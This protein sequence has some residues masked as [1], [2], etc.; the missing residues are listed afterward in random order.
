MSEDSEPNQNGKASNEIESWDSS[1]KPATKAV[2]D[3]KQFRS[4]HQR[5]VGQTTF[6]ESRN[7]A[8]IIPCER[9]YLKFEGNN[10]TG[11]QKDRIAIALAETASKQLYSG[12]VTATC[13]NF[14]A[15][16]AYAANH[17]RIPEAHIFIPKGYHVPKSRMKIMKQHNAEIH[18]IEGT[19]EHAVFYSSEFA[20]E[21]NMYDANP[22]GE[23]VVSISLEAYADIAYEIYKG[24]R[25]APDY[26]LCPVGNGSTL[27]GIHLGFKKLLEANRI[28]NLPRM[29]AVSTRRGNPIIKSFKS[30]SRDIIDLAPSEIVE[31]RVNEPLTNWHAFDGQEALTAIY[32]SNGFGEYASD[33]KMLEYTRILKEEEGLI[34]H[35]ASASTLAVLSSITRN[36]MA[37]KGTYVAVLTGRYS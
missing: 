22:G 23:Q 32:D 26:V 20:K 1:A 29:V 10:P 31:T 19:Y 11:T 14:G 34:V 3:R 36:D 27:A 7:I 15:A 28:R 25:R 16:V 37:L 5:L 30:K 4:R 6:T 18:F 21:N 9:L 2:T 13:G 24:L 12:I 35:P 17:C 8:R 33:T